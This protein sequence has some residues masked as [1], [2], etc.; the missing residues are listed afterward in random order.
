MK[1]LLLIIVLGWATCGFS[2]FKK[3]EVKGAELNYLDNGIGTP[4]IFIHGGME[5]YR[6]WDPQI[7][8]F[9]RGYRVITYSRRFNYPNKNLNEVT[10]FS[11][12]T[13]GEDLAR[14]I[15]KLNLPP[16]HV[17]GHSFGAYVALLLTVKYPQL[18]RSLT[19][20]E[21]PVVAWLPGLANGQELYDDFYNRLIN[22]L[23]LDFA[24]NDT[25]A[26]LRHTSIY[27]Y[28]ADIVQD[29]PAEVRNQLIA[30]L[31][32]WR[33][34]SLSKNA[35][36]FVTKEEV[37]NIKVPVLLLS[38]GKTMPLLQVTNAELKRLLPKATVFELAN[39]THDYWITNPTEMGDALMKFLKAIQK[40]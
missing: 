26:V 27:F 4:I 22:P 23:R 17:V 2:Q 7:D 15:T 30:N 34:M 32:E 38:A 11:A 39:G 20:S 36:P 33:A 19:L 8:S 35:F 3:I 12:Q 10:D 40:K 16:V 24:Q 37:Q 5:D 31:H 29:I 25:A 21:P 28:G 14:L 13:E 1:T 18:V 9:S 6:T